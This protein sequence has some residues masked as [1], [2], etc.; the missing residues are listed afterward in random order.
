[1]ESKARCVNCRTDIDVLAT[2]ADGDHIKCGACGMQHRVLRTNGAL[3]LVVADVAP[4]RDQ[5]RQNEQRIERLENELRAAR[6]SIGIGANGIGVGVIY[7][8]VKL[9]WDEQL[10]TRELI[11]NALLIAL[12]CGVALELANFMFLSKRRLM[13]QLSEEIEI[14]TNETKE[15]QRKI[16]EGSLRR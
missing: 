4:L 6:G 16:R 1:M 2:Y 3:R 10:L 13:D 8:L 14:M 5:V 15:L 9:A 7:L 12:L 11:V